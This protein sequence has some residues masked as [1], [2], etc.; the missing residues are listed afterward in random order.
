MFSSRTLVKFH[1]STR[2]K[3][4]LMNSVRMI[5]LLGF[6]VLELAACADSSQNEPD[7]D[8]DVTVTYAYEWRFTNESSF[9]VTV[10]CLAANPCFEFLVLTPGATT[11]VPLHEPWHYIHYTPVETVDSY[12]RCV[13][14]SW[15]WQD[16]THTVFFDRI[17]EQ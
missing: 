14:V 9:Q 6:V 13:L 12:V 1:F 5:V 4:A 7:I 8:V 17:Y 16:C 2:R 15:E 10:K 11:T 3:A